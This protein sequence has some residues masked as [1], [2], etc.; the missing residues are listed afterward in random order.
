MH[1]LVMRKY[2][3]GNKYMLYSVDATCYFFYVILD[4]VNSMLVLWL[5]REEI[6]KKLFEKNE[7][8]T[9]KKA[10]FCVLLCFGLLSN[11]FSSIILVSFIGADVLCRLI[12]NLKRHEFSIKKYFMESKKTMYYFCVGHYSNF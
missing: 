9:Y 3:S 1:F 10:I 6:L 2:S 7:V 5:L 12:D 4:L 8:P 11:L